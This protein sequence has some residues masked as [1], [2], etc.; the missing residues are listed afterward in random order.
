[1]PS[2]K[3]DGDPVPVAD[4]PA[5]CPRCH[6]SI[7]VL[8]RNCGIDLETRPVE[9]CQAVFQCPACKL[10]FLGMYAVV[11]NAFKLQ[12]IEPR[13]AKVQTFGPVHV[14]SPQ[15]TKIYNQAAHAEALNMDEIAGL[16]Y[17]ES[18]EFLIKDY[19]ISLAPDEEDA[20]KEEFLGQ[21]IK[22]RLSDK[23][24][25]LAAERATWLGNDESHYVRKWVNH[26]IE[27]LKNLIRITVSGISEAL[28]YEAYMKTFDEKAKGDNSNS[29]A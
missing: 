23:K 1:M 7:Q 22:G 6:K 24:I 10:L 4:L 13:N 20:I 27:D 15:F 18:L 3:I 2:I 16:G 17:R 29:K 25:Q 9:R 21:T 11:G 5:E 28:E 12:F 19:C 26:D 14:L 8:N